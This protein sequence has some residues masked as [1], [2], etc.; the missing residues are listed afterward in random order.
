M[1]EL[2]VHLKNYIPSRILPSVINFFAIMAY[3]RLLEPEDYGYYI[4]VLT[5]ISFVSAIGFGWINQANIRLYEKYKLRNE[6]SIFISSNIT[7]FIILVSVFSTL[8]LI[9]I[10]LIKN[11]ISNRL[12]ILFMIGTFTLFSNGILYFIQSILRAQHKSKIFRNNSIFQVFFSVAMSILL[13]YLFKMKSESILI[14]TGLVSVIIAGFI[15][16]KYFHMDYKMKLNKHVGKIQ[17]KSF[18]YGFPMAGAAFGGLLLSVSDR[19]MIKYFIGAKAVGIYSVGYRLSEMS[20]LLFA[21]IL[22]LAAFPLIVRKYEKQGKY[23]TQK[24]IT[25]LTGIYFVTMLPIVFGMAAI[26]QDIVLVFLGEKYAK[27]Y[28]V[29]PW[30]TAGAFFVGLTQFINKSFELTEKTYNIFIFTLIAG[31]I[32]IISNIYLI[33]R[34]GYIGAA[35]STIVSYFVYLILSTLFSNRKFKWIL[36]WATILKSLIASL[37]ILLI[38]KNLLKSYEFSFYSLLFKVTIAFITYPI[39]LWF[40]KEKWTL[41]LT[42]KFF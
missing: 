20:I 25:N 4:L 17:K 32:N 15:F 34:F 5:T 13:I 7:L 38:L 36:P 21:G 41:K 35:Y 22:M 11:N 18:Y 3:T 2:I 26:S 1:H 29:L 30:V 16:G 23:E 31:I 6:D 28:S 12:Y 10:T 42:R 24:L 39:L 33:P 40:M 8:W 37:I 27:A 9:T 19:Y 14:S